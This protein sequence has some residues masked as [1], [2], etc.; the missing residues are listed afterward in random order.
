MKTIYIVLVLCMMTLLAGCNA[1]RVHSREAS[2]LKPLLPLGTTGDAVVPVGLQV[3]DAYALVRV[4]EVN[5][6]SG[7]VAE[8]TL[9]VCLQGMTVKLVERDP[10][11]FVSHFDLTRLSMKYGEPVSIEPGSQH[12]RIRSEV[13]IRDADERRRSIEFAASGVA[14]INGYVELSSGRKGWGVLLDTRTGK[15]IGDVLSVEEQYYR[16]TPGRGQSVVISTL[17]SHQAA[18]PLRRA[19]LLVSESGELGLVE[20]WQDLALPDLGPLL[21]GVSQRDRQLCAV[22]LVRP[23]AGV[24]EV[25]RDRIVVCAAMVV[26]LPAEFQRPDRVFVERGF[27]AYL[28]PMPEESR[29]ILVDLL[30]GRSH[31]TVP[32]GLSSQSVCVSIGSGDRAWIT[33]GRLLWSTVFP[34]DRTRAAGTP[35]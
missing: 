26:A 15:A 17:S 33:D 12:E 28:S 23:S 22:S 7:S 29:V 18:A 14:F 6:E 25:S 10:D 31:Q 13:V 11:E 27:V 4:Q 5:F 9:A 34:A 30:T 16:L 2:A 32:L 35:R 8:K 19:S 20:P 24:V 1:D 21:I 3:S